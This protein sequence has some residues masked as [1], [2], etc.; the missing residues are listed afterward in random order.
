MDAAPVVQIASKFAHSDAGNARGASTSSCPRSLSNP[1]TVSQLATIKALDK[2][3]AELPE[4]RACYLRRRDAFLA[5]LNSLPG[6]SCAKPGGAFY[7]FPDVRGWLGKRHGD[8]LLNTDTDVC[9]ALLAKSLVATV[10]GVEFGA[11]GFLRISYALSDR[12][13]AEA[14]KRIREFAA[15][16]R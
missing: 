15:A 14:I 3:P 9:E 2:D 10:P 16:L 8:T 5:A 13:V 4:W 7:V 1:A 11:P 6:V 12:D